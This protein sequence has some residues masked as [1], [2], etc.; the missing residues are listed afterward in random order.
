MGGL[1]HRMEDTAF[2]HFDKLNCFL[3]AFG[4]KTRIERS[5]DGCATWAFDGEH[6]DA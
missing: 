2:K 5:L 1:K 4:A 3:T 6:R